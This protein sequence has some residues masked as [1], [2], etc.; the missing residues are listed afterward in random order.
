LYRF[1]KFIDEQEAAEVNHEPAAARSAN[2]VRLMTIHASKG[3]EFP[4]VVLAG[5]GIRFNLRDLS[6]DVLVDDELGLCPKVFPPNTRTKY[7][8][9]A[10]WLAAQHERR[11]FLGEEL[12]LLYVAMT[13]ARDKLL[14][15]G[16]ATKQDEAERWQTP[17]AITNQA[18]LK[19]GSY[20]D[21]LRLWFTN[22]PATPDW[23]T[24]SEGRNALLTWKFWSSASA[25][26][27]SESRDG[28]K[29][30]E[31]LSAP[32]AEQLNRIEAMLAA[33]YQHE[34]AVA[35]PAKTTVTAIRHR[36]ADQMDDEA[37]R[38]FQMTGPLLVSRKLDSKLSAAE[39]G[40]AHHTFLQFVALK[41]TATELDL[42]NEATQLEHDGALSSEQLGVL[43]FAA[44]TAFWQSDL[45]KELRS[46]PENLV[47][48]EMPFTARFRVSEIEKL[49]RSG[50]GSKDFA[51]KAD[52]DFIVVQGIA[53][54]AVLLPK[55]IWLL[56]FKTDHITTAELEDKVKLYAPQLKI[57][58][59]ALARIFNRPITRCCVHFLAARETRMIEPITCN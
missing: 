30:I 33:R 2:A 18:L 40:T 11:A 14:L 37:R 21:W 58:A 20:L 13:R 22:Q 56:D 45:G 6:G 41:R 57:Y 25:S 27:I 16:T 42:R 50:L 28:S 31:S 35:Q 55:E 43:D 51:L 39:I 34:G 15:V 46:L 32:T 12:R 29:N 19:A 36:L 54:L 7:P 4:I 26:L 48:R 9:I 3:L 53:D 5:M 52:A 17:V 10:H 47:N 59:L 23:A 8:S 38:V 49:L 24:A 1:L 44:L